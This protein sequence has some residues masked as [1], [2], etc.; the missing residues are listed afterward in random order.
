MSIKENEKRYC[1]QCKDYIISS[2]DELEEEY[3]WRFSGKMI[4]EFMKSRFRKFADDDEMQGMVN[5]GLCPGCFG[6]LEKVIE[7]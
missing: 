6:R 4:E 3:E 2:Y 7:K 1:P 5:D